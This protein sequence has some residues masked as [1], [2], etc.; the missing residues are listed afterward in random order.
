MRE[1][2]ELSGATGPI[3]WFTGNHV[4]AN[5]LMLFFIAGGLFSA[6][7]MR[8]EILPAIDP[9]L[10]QVTVPFPGATP[11]E[12]ADSITQRVEEAIIG[13][14]GVERISSIASE[15]LGLV[16]VEIQDFADADQVYNDVETVV[17][18]LTSFPPEDAERPAIS[19]IRVTPE[20]MTLAVFGDAGE[21]ALRFWTD[22]IEDGLQ[23]LDGVSLTTVRGIRD[24]EVSIEVAEETLRKHRLSLEEIG[25]AVGGF[26][27]DIAAGNIGS[28]QG[29]F[30]LRVEERRYVRED[31]ESIPIRTLEDGSTLLLG[32]V[33][34]VLDQLEDTNVVSLYNGK[35]AAFIDIER[36]ESQ[37]TL[38]VAREIRSYL[39]SLSLPAGLRVEVSSDQTTILKDRISLMA[40]NAIVGF[41]LVFLLLVVFFDL[42]LAV[43]TS[44]A[45]PIS[46]L[47]GLMVI[48][49]LGYSINMI[50][51]F[52][53]IVVLGIVVDDGVVTGESIFAEQEKAKGDPGAALRGVRAVIA[54]VTI[55]VLTTMCA[56]A[57]LIF[58][59]GT[60]GQIIG[61]VPVVV[62]PILL[63]SLL[64]AYFILPSHLANP[65]RWSRGILSDLR[66]R[67]S[68]LLERFVEKRLLPLS[69]FCLRWRYA[70]IAAFLAIGILSVGLVQ[71]GIVRFIFFPQVE[72]DTIRIQ[73]AM[74][75]GSPF[76]STRRTVSEIEAAVEEVR[77]IVDADREDS[78]SIVSV[79]AT[80]GSRRQ[81]GTLPGEGGQ[82][83]GDH[84]AD[85]TIQLTPSDFRDYSANEIVALIRERTDEI[86]GIHE[87]TFQSS[88]VG[89]EADIEFELYHARTDLLIA[90]AAALREELAAIEGTFNVS[91]SFEEGKA[92][93]LYRL[94]PEGVAAGLTPRDLGRQL[95]SAYFGLEVDRIQRGPSEVIVYV[96]YPKEDRERLSSLEETRIRLPRGEEVA[97]STVAEPIVRS[98][99]TT[100][101]SV[102]G[103]RII[104]LSADA[105]PNTTTPN[106]I[107]R[108][109]EATSL[110]ELQQEYPGL[111]Y[112]F[113][114]ETKEQ[115]EDLNSLFSNMMIALLLIYVLLGSQLRSY[116]QPLIIMAA[117]PF[118][119]AGAI[120]GHFLLGYD[121]TFISL[122]GVVALAGVVVN[123]SVV[124]LDY[125]N[126]RLDEGHSLTESARL[127]VARRFRPILL[128]T[129]STCLGLLPILTETSIQARFLIPMV[130]SLSM[131]ILF[132]TPII[133]FLVPCLTLVVDDA[134]RVSS[135]L[136]NRL[137]TPAPD[138]AP[139][140]QE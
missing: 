26:S 91:T 60:I 106:E 2:N 80:L 112:T 52:A 58:S 118:G 125:L 98:G 31:F 128:T 126:Q 44:A 81:P 4:A 76:E 63:V 45:I 110:P 54:P 139:V 55:G 71:G 17:N 20:V 103:R 108:R 82:D 68:G 87:L 43:W 57:P 33:A 40:R 35:P 111:R 93:L 97:L 21:T 140:G 64:E 8:T 6:L 100:I 74:P 117:I 22:T 28:R 66:R 133:L 107:I 114:G 14:E 79:S 49:F 37:D 61:V 53:L 85:L 101:E 59:T 13:L 16:N 42:K 56:F 30:L 119:F 25:D 75:V 46:F 86:P 18:S 24:Y 95:R 120:I 89:A 47:G 122:F 121:L 131:G 7:N 94:K 11:D 5:I 129:L 132:A 92:E 1:R 135:A 99:P 29:D 67:A 90:A 51:L 105:D 130:V 138:P 102:D 27:S 15:G 123:D 36:S 38:A 10:I 9:G 127:A 65:T 134:K 84:L 34:E 50:S 115:E 88:L 19:R 72:S 113:S 137:R 83:S 41:V 104:R 124:L 136:W 62:I 96:R 3:A 109:L 116:L 73:L 69:S 12:V 32:D 39:E 78:S 77:A 70:T 23:D 48:H